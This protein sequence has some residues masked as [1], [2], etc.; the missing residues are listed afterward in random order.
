MSFRLRLLIASAIFLAIWVAFAASIAR[1]L[2]VER[3]LGHADAIQVL[4]GSQAYQERTHKAA[5]LYEQGVSSKIFLT[6]DGIQAGWDQERQR[7]PY[8]VEKAYWE[9]IKQGVPAAS[10][11]ILSPV[12]EG[13]TKGEANLV[14]G[15]MSERKIESLL[16][17][18]SA[19]HTRRTQWTFE[20][21]IQRSYPPLKLGITAA[22]DVNLFTWWL[23]IR[24]WQM[25]GLEYVKTVYYCMYY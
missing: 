24:G 5:E 21:S 18:T 11:E 14:I 25:V 7:N 9:L 22:S 13:G 15:A 16:L 6:N 17:V 4:G 8:F 2:I 19:Y 23:S 1:Y 3:P 12:V 20:R 10:I